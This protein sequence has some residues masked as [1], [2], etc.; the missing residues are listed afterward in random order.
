MKKVRTIALIVLLLVAS[1]FSAFALA[2]CGSKETF[3]YKA[4]EGSLADRGYWVS[5]ASTS[6]S[7]DIEIPSEY[8]DKP[9][10]GIWVQGFKDC[11]KI[12]SI[13]IPNSVTHISDGAFENCYQAVINIPTSVTR[14]GSTAFDGM[15]SNGT[16]NRNHPIVHINYSGTKTQ[17]LEIKSMDGYPFDTR[18]EITCTDGIYTR[19]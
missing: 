17:W 18:C 19:T 16:V 2:G 1:V 10:F 6:I 3:S 13:T 8:N 4:A 12:T 14:I 15:N 5:A 9:V 11:T 7:G